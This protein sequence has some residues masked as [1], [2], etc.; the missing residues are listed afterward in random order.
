M[1][2]TA[3]PEGTI[4]LLGCHTVITT[5]VDLV[6][7]LLDNAI[8]AKANS[9]DVFVS[10][11]VV[12]KI[13]VR[14]NGHGIHPD[15]YNFLGRAGRTSKI[16]SFEDL[17]TLGG[18]TL[19]FRGQALASANNL[20]TVT[21]TTR[22][23]ENS[24]AM[25]LNLSPGVGGV[26]NQKRTS[27]PIGTTVSV[28][29]LYNRLPVRKHAAVK[30]ALKNLVKIKQLL[31]AYALA[32]SNIR[33]LFRV[34]GGSNRQAFCYSP[35]PGAGVQEAV[36]QIFGI[37]TTS[38]CMI[39]KSCSDSGNEDSQI[40]E[41]YDKMSIEAVLPKKTA[42]QSRIAKGPFFSV[43]SRPVS[44]QRGTMKKLL[45]IFKA[46]F[47]EVMRTTY[48]ETTFRDSFICINIKC[49]PG[50]YDPNIEPSK[51]V[52]LFADETQV[53][54]IFERLCEEVYCTPE[55]HGPFITVGKRQLL[56]PPLRTPPTS[57]DS[58]RHEEMTTAVP[59]KMPKDLVTPSKQKPL[60][61]SSS[62][63][64]KN[65][66]QRSALRR[67][68]VPANTA[69]TVFAF[70]MSA[71]PGISSDE[72]AE[73]MAARFQQ[74]E[75]LRMQDEDENEPPVKAL[76]PWTIAKMNAPAR[77]L[78]KSHPLLAK[79]PQY[80]DQIEEQ[81]GLVVPD[82]IS[83]KLPILR[84]FGEASAGLGFPHVTRSGIMPTPYQQH[85]LLG[86]QNPLNDGTTTIPA[87]QDTREPNLQASEAHSRQALPILRHSTETD[88]AARLSH[89]GISELSL[90]PLVQTRLGTGS[91][92]RGSQR[93]C[94]AQVQRHIND[95]PSKANPP[96]REP[97]RVS[98]KNINMPFPN[99]GQID[100]HVENWVNNQCLTGD[101]LVSTRPQ[102]TRRT[103]APRTPH[104]GN[105]DTVAI[106]DGLPS[107]VIGGD[108]TWVDGDSRKYLIKRQRS[109]ADHRRRGRQPLKRTKT[110][111]LPLETVPERQ[112]MHHL[113]LPLQVDTMKLADILANVV[114][115]DGSYSN[116]CEEIKSSD[117]MNL[118]DVMEIEVRLNDLLS[119]WTEQVFGEKSELSLYLRRQVKGKTVA[120]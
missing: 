100:S 76:N 12:D 113:V 93:T 4:R 63:I 46:R 20:G 103:S 101:G 32:R 51:D 91:H 68:P 102:R 62:P 61:S 28:I 64:H 87:T 34:L 79:Q 17:R 90:D 56:G 115:S 95:I 89:G 52:V 53:I 29:G 108:G 40:V 47:S 15:D 98:T 9:V 30:D 39:R 67:Q 11:N 18:T 81:S 1:A 73:M 37:E 111:K 13:E 10:P 14:D 72:E 42:D 54:Q 116:Y 109:E 70:D 80:L 65:P 110:D 118:D 27:A 106:Q 8:D 78:V 84:P 6:K 38:Q 26:N 83:E 119:I 77:P 92:P 2:I 3:L 59:E 71:D 86:F 49:S 57:S 69:R 35:R 24:T 85:E 60:P 45:A 7:E 99:Q 5:P 105:T 58:P 22:T 25:K 23:A 48:G 114:Q 75:E 120:A 94:K 36:T 97:K 107:S 112:E 41:D 31:Q 96:Y 88:P 44:A 50:S 82:E 21:V 66:A 74:Q 117:H 55:G 33:L 104:F 19:G 16:T 43:D